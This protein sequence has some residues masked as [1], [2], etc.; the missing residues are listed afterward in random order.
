MAPSFGRPS[1]LGQS[2]H[3]TLSTS[4]SAS[5][6][7]SAS[8]SSAG[9]SRLPSDDDNDQGGHNMPFATALHLLESASSVSSSSSSSS[10]ALDN[11]QAFLERNL[12][13]LVKP[14]EPFTRS[15]KL[16]RA[17]VP[18]NNSSKRKQSHVVDDLAHRFQIDQHSAR[19]VLQ[20]V[21]D[22]E[23][24]AND[25][26]LSEDHWDRITAYVFEERMAILGIVALL[27][28]AQDDPDTDNAVHQLSTRL[29][30]SILTADFAVSILRAFVQRTRDAL[31]DAVRTSPTHSLFWAKQLLREQKALLEIVFL[32]F[33]SPLPPNGPIFL[34]VLETIA[35]TQ[36]GQRQSLFGYFDKEAA[37]IVAEIG[38]LWTILAIEALNLELAIEVPSPIPAPG[39]KPLP[40]TSIYHAD[41]L[42]SINAAVETLVQVDTERASPILLGWAFLL[43][44]VTAFLIDRG[45]PEAYHDFASQ[46]LRVE[47]P[48]TSSSSSAQPL[49]Q[50]YATHALSPSSGFFTALLAILHS[51][52]LG[53]SSTS[54]SNLVEPNAVGY[55]SVLRGLV[56]CLPLLIRLSF[57]T[58][59]QLSA[60]FK[61][62]SSLFENRAASILCVQFWQDQG[63]ELL[64]SAFDASADASMM[65]TFDERTTQMLGELETISIAQARFP[66][67][68][69][70]F[71]S[72]VRALC[73][74]VSGLLP[75]TLDDA[76]SSATIE[77]EELASKCAA[78]AFEWLAAL[79][80]LT[81]IVPSAP[82]MTPLPYEV[83]VYPTVTY[84]SI[85]PIV[86]SRSLS[87]PVGVMGKLVSQQGQKPVVVQWDLKWSAWRLFGDVL[88]NFAGGRR[89]SSPAKGRQQPK[90][91]DGGAI[92]DVFGDDSATRSA[93]TLPIEWEDEQAQEEDVVVVLDIFRAMLKND[94]SLG[95]TLVEHL[96]VPQSAN[97]MSDE[98]NDAPRYDLVEVLFRILDRVMSTPSRSDVSTRLVSSLLG[99][100]AALLPSYPGVCWTLLR[101]S[102]LLFPSTSKASSA[103][104]GT[105]NRDGSGAGRHSILVNERLPGK[106][107]ITLALLSLVRALVLEEQVTSAAISADFE[108]IKIDVLVRALAWVRDEV[109]PSYASWR[110][111]NLSE[112]YEVARRIVQLYTLVLEEGELASGASQGQFPPVATIVLD[113]LL[114]RAT[115]GQLMPLITTISNGPDH[116]INLRKAIRFHEAQGSEDLIL[117]SLSLIRKLLRI[118]QRI[119]GMSTSL[120]EKLVLSPSSTDGLSI[121]AASNLAFGSGSTTKSTRVEWVE[122][123]AQFIVSPLNHKVSIEAAKVMT[124][125]CLGSVNAT[126][127]PPSLTALLGGATR[128][129]EWVNKV[130]QIA[131]N[132]M[133]TE[134][135]QVAVWDMISSIVET[136]PSLAILIVTGR[137]FPFFIEGD[138]AKLLESADA[139]KEN[140]ALTAAEEDA[141]A[142]YKSLAPP[143]I[144]PLPR[145]ALGVALETIG[146]WNETWTDQP[147]LLAS[148]L[149]FFDF[150]FQ[151]LVDYGDALDDFRGRPAPWNAFVKIAFKS[152]GESEPDDDQGVRDYCHRVMAKAH[153][154]RVLALDIGVVLERPSPASATSAKAL[155]KA[156]SDKTQ[157]SNAL[158]TAMDS[159]CAPQLQ[160]GVFD[161]LRESFPEIDIETLRMPAQSH[162]LEG[163]REYGATYLYSLSILRRRLDGFMSEANAA[164]LGP[165]AFSDVIEQTGK[166]NLNFSLVDAQISHTRSWRQLLELALPLISNDRA[167]SMTVLDVAA[168][169]VTSSIAEEDRGG[170][171]VLTVQDERLSILLIM[172]EVLQGLELDQVRGQLVKLIHGI[173]RIFSSETLEPLESVLRRNVPMFHQTLFR[174]AYF[175]YR[176]L[177]GADR[178]SF[179]AEQ[180]STIAG[181]TEIVLRSMIT[182]AHDLFVIARASQDPDLEQDV[183]LASAVLSQLVHSS[184]IPHAGVWLAHCQEVDF[185]RAAFD[186]FV[187]MDQIDGRPLYAQHVLDLCL[188]IATS[189][190]RAAEQMALEGLMTALTNNALS[191]AAEAGTISIT[192]RDGSSQ[193]SYEHEMWTSM[194]KL[195]VA[196]I[197]ALGDSTQFFEVEV[198][199]FVRLHGQQIACAMSWNADSVI[200]LPGLEELAIST[201]L[202]H[203]VIQRAAFLADSQKGSRGPA[204]LREGSIGIEALA[205][206]FAEQSLH[207]L[208]HIVYAILHPNHLSNLIEPT[209]PEERSWIEKDAS[210]SVDPNG[211]LSKRPVVATVT[212][213]L[214]QLARGVVDALVA[215]TNAFK[216]LST[217]PTE[218]RTDRAIVI[219]T[220]TVS[221]NEKA[222]I[223]TLFD[224][225]SFCLDTLRQSP[226][227][228][229]ST[230]STS[231]ITPLMPYFWRTM[232]SSTAQTLEGVLLLSTSQLALWLSKP[233][234]S[235]TRASIAMRREISGELAT[236][237]G[238]ILDR[239]GA[240]STSTLGG[241]KGAKEG[242]GTS[243]EMMKVLKMF[244]V[245]R[246]LER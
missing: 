181:A 49:F 11:V 73:V 209:N 70:G 71:A 220:A 83:A 5:A 55:L 240:R 61:V 28:R 27:L 143:A 126:P 151:H 160:S 208:Q 239:A 86:L 199:G 63:V 18:A 188:A 69:T 128:S 223:G 64:R 44:K 20:S 58:S 216:V 166:L 212:L 218:W 175:A 118:R 161:L 237:L 78:T 106:Y 40:T 14:Y 113:A 235:P 100:I 24:T 185:F 67:Q 204:S 30:P 119:R 180:Q 75:D 29:L 41:N 135:L 34:L 45:V 115:V 183:A 57:L 241:V 76:T 129:Q 182:A 164:N 233:D 1:P 138:Q 10:T 125:L 170:Q 219:P 56:T 109:W 167:A 153:A 50:L 51:S 121:A 140:K 134:T 36:W 43:S 131:A 103:T 17:L 66:V 194:L 159:S 148:V 184:F 12:S 116:I 136:Q 87:I 230:T 163:S 203:G 201:A 144:K 21:Y 146:I 165:E 25:E 217:D 96:T 54:T 186:V 197:A 245:A 38:Y 92:E 81:C 173:G 88:E 19:I 130:L 137:H 232:Q 90:K 191:S 72:I 53:G 85:R 127:R 42:K 174:I 111:V 236:D 32:I 169:L 65:M 48:S 108:E 6:S 172:I 3:N 187:H 37:V 222:S 196:L 95:T 13:Q 154:V 221:S 244:V 114:L 80:S 132:P 117:A 150:V 231:S 213:A 35:E 7:A 98:E 104:S 195:V 228:A 93:H 215:H 200:S 31:P 99:L 91:K 155:I 246:L 234:P 8:T 225:A 179:S 23:R 26:P 82:S 120:F 60:H 59:E 9:P 193:R 84:R 47:A 227:A 4:A 149:R 162:P 105:W 89:Q 202:M 242:A 152:L 133:G 192:A 107:P 52:L 238:G 226:P 22:D 206:I 139:G 101:G 177:A 157:L 94:P 97:T 168:D 141:R 62:F 102:D 39:E 68:F 176:K 46:S 77:A 124:L 156:L 74:G 158:Q 210:T 15:R 110:F 178:A 211:D 214:L 122:C 205:T 171:I 190:A 142:L 145:T 147:D 229:S 189:S 16:T 79:D 2:D 198:T 243:G 224:L 112:K 33:Y 123:L 207:L